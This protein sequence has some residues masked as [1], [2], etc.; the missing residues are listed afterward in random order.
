VPNGWN[1]QIIRPA[2]NQNGNVNPIYCDG[3]KLST[4]LW[5]TTDIYVGHF[6]SGNCQRHCRQPWEERQVV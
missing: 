2:E 3:P 4:I 1:S 6:A 5:Q